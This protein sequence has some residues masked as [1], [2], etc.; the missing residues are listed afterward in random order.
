MSQ[1]A[2]EERYF[3]SVMRSHYAEDEPS[4]RTALADWQERAERGENDPVACRAGCSACCRHLVPVWRVEALA[5]FAALEELPAPIKQRIADNL[6]DWQPAFEQWLID[7][8]TA[9]L[10]LNPATAAEPFSVVATHYWRRQI[11]CPFLI[12]ENCS[13]YANRPAECRYYYALRDPAA[14]AEPDRRLVLIPSELQR[15]GDSLRLSL[16]AAEQAYGDGLS[17][18]QLPLWSYA[19]AFRA[20]V[21]APANGGDPS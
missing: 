13:V 6:A 18:A 2:P 20:A 7:A 3:A 9:G 16:M 1:L 10:D 21:E 19:E 8:E 14:C 15:D 12:D 17:V 11:P 4:R 5:L